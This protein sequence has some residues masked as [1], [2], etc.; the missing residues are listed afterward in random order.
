MNGVGIFGVELFEDERGDFLVN[1]IA[2]VC[3]FIFLCLF[4]F[5]FCIFDI[6]GAI[7]FYF[8]TFLR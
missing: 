1:E 2:P 3:F 6:F 4:L 7:F 5:Y 8:S